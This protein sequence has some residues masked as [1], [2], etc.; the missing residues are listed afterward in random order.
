MKKTVTKTGASRKLLSKLAVAGLLAATMQ[1]VLAAPSFALDNGQAATPPMGWNSWNQVRCYHLTEQ[2]VKD[3]ADAMASKLAAAGYDHIVVDD[4]YQGGRDNDGV[5]F[6]DP[7]RFPSGM[8]ALGEYIHN[9]NLKYGVYMVPGSETCANHWDSYPI[10]NL[11]SY[12]HETT[13]AR[14]L[15]TWGVDYLKYDW[16]R[17]DETNGLSRIPAFTKMRDELQK[18]DRPVTYAISEYGVAQPWTWASP[19]ANMWRTTGDIGPTWD[20]VVHIVNS[21]AGLASYGGPGHFN[22]PDM[23]QVGNGEFAAGQ[24][25][26]LAKNRSHFAMWSMLAAPLFLGTDL[27]TLNP[28]ILDIV[29]NEGIIAIDQDELGQGAQ[30]IVVSNG[31]QVWARPL[32]DGSYAVAFFNTTGQQKGVVTT[33]LSAIGAEAGYYRLTDAWTGTSGAVS[34]DKI[35]APSI[36]PY[37]TVVY[38]LHPETAPVAETA[39]THHLSDLKPVA[40]QQNDD[41]PLQTNLSVEKNVL[42]AAGTLYRYGLGIQAPTQVT[43]ALDNK[44]TGLKG[45]LAL[46]DE[47][48]TTNPDYDKWGKPGFSGKIVADGTTIWQSGELSTVNRKEDFQ[49]DLTG[50]KQLQLVTDAGATDAYDHADWLDLGLTCTSNPAQAEPETPITPATPVTP[51]VNKQLTVNQNGWFVA[52]YFISWEEQ[53]TSGSWVRKNWAGNGQN[54]TLGSKDVITIPGSARNLN[55]QVR[56]AT[57]LAWAWWKDAY[58]ATNVQLGQNQTLDIWGTTLSPRSRLS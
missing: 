27:V 9:Q 12:G 41:F 51:V 8:Q 30:R 10:Y 54:R 42:S 53:T 34:T 58:R 23:L 36:A 4:C 19:I 52:Q 43:Y 35:T 13:D 33:S 11:G 7:H 46:D 55:I 32:A 40:V 3:T 25:Y 6:S 14:T 1:P 2:L 29:T 21:Q 45:S 20:S 22:D 31:V 16:C 57:G 28:Q 44:C 48:A 5:L 26:F 18:I 38:R 50:V 56:E 49:L 37:D 47:V 24:P 17:A 15:N 39:A